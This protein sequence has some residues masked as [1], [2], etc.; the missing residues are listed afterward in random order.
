MS[1]VDNVSKQFGPR[2]GPKICWALSESN[3]FGTQM[4]FQKEFFEKVDLEK[5]QQT[6]QNMTNF[7]GGRELSKEFDC[8]KAPPSVVC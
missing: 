5:N 3:L 4:V 6:T 2:S 8:D 7:Q 1:S